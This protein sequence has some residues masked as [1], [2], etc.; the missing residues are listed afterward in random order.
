MGETWSGGEDEVVELKVDSES[1]V[2][3]PAVE[4]L[5]SLA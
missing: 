5:E 2:D 1:V 3:P 4:E